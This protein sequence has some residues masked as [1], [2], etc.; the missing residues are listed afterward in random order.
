MSVT[1]D[2]AFVNNAVIRCL[3]DKQINVWGTGLLE[4]NYMHMRCISH[5]TN[6]IVFHGLS[7]MGMS[8]RRVQEAIKY[9]LSSPTRAARFK[10]CAVFKRIPC[11]KLVSMDVATR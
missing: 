9:V 8:V 7:H 5:I 11:T 10:D 6:L 2:N 3:K 1:V 4:G